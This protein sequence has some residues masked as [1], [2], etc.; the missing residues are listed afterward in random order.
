MIWNVYRHDVNS[1]EIEVFNV[2]DHYSFN[3]DVGKILKKKITYN[4]LSEKLKSSVM[5][6]FW[7]RYE[8]EVVIT[9]FPP[10]IDKK[11]MGVVVNEYDKHP[12]R[13]NVN[14]EVGIKIDIHD[15]LMLNWDSFV[16]YVWQFAQ[17]INDIKD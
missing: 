3:E 4:E 15:Q 17:Q 1:R 9:T 13:M 2:F 10:Y 7:C 8:Y 14:P 12:Y 5:Y 16:W 11:E 6:Y